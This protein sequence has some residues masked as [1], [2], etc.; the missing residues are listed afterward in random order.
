MSHPAKGIL[1]TCWEHEQG[2]N[3]CFGRVR[4][5]QTR[6]MGLSGRECSS[7]V[8]IPVN[9]P[10]L[11]LPPV[12]DLEVSERLRKDREGVDPFTQMVQ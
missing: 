1:Q 2:H 9:P 11:L 3:T 6:E 12:V 7:T 10:W 4:N 5:T 8:A